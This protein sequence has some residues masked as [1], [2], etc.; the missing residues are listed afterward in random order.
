M[1]ASSN[2]IGR[3]LFFLSLTPV[4]VLASNPFLRPGGA[5]PQP[6]KVEKPAPPPPPPKP[7]N[8]NMEFRGYYKF[9]DQWRIGLFDK[10]KNSGFW[11]VVG[12]TSPEGDLEIEGFDEV[13]E[14]VLLKGGTKLALVS[15]AGTPIPLPGAPAKPAPKALPTPASRKPAPAIPQRKR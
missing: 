13:S 5:R 4:L 7:M 12:E 6:P 3:L 2:L 14:E 11:M 8:P 15:P 9:K 10:A 1:M